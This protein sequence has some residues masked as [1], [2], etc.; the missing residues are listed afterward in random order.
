VLLAYALMRMYWFP[1]IFL[2]CSGGSTALSR[3]QIVP[4]SGLGLFGAS[5]PP[6]DEWFPLKIKALQDLDTEDGH[7]RSLS[8]LVDSIGSLLGYD[9]PSVVSLLL[10]LQL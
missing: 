4:S 8:F 3:T 2:Q 1:Y 9:P 7:L 6:A 5:F 10:S